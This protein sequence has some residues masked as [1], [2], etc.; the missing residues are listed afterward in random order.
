MAKLTPISWA[1]LVKGL[2]QFGFDGPFQGGKHPYMVKGNLVLTNPNPHRNE[3]SIDL[4]T[5]VLRQAGISREQ[6]LE[7]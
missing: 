1:E 6:W 3:V 5:R 7:R 4:L 2:M